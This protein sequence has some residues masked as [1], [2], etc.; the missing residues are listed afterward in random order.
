M[1]TGLPHFSP[2]VEAKK[3]GPSPSK[4]KRILSSLCLCF[5]YGGNAV[6]CNQ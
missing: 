5:V 3:L 4:G 6:Q 2:V 1:G